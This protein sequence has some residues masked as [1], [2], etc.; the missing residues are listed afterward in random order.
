VPDTTGTIVGRLATRVG[1]VL[2]LLVVGAALLAPWLTAVDPNA[3]VTTPYRG[4]LPPT[5]G[6][7]LGTDTLG[8]DVWARLVFGARTSLVVGVSS[9]LLSLVVG[10]SV[11]LVAGYFGGLVDSALMWVVDLLLTLPSLLLLVVLS[12]VF[13]PT[14][15]TVPLVIG[16]VGWTTFARTVRSEVMSVRARDYVTAARAIGATHARVIGRHVLP[17]VLPNVIVLAALGMSGAVTLDAGL[18]YLGL[19]VPLPTPSWG[20]MISEAQTYF[21]VAPWLVVFPGIAIALTAIGF[22]LIGQGLLARMGSSGS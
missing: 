17:A 20:R 12:T 13:P 15:W 4:P 1:P 8:R 5:A 9:M 10:V 21:A 22:N 7:P 16:S 2:V 19:G 14:I 6:H 18:S 11:G 3:I